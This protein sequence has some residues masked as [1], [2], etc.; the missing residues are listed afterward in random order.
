MARLQT[1]YVI[2]GSKQQT[3]F[4]ITLDV[5]EKALGRL[6]QV[7][8]YIQYDIDRDNSWTVQVKRVDIPTAGTKRTV[9][10]TVEFVEAR[11]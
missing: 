7:G 6:P 4:D 1:N 5:D 2:Q 9:T 3:R 11:I 10:I 8:D